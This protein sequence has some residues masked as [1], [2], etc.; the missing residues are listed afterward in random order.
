MSLELLS[1]PEN[2]V[3]LGLNENF[4]ISESL[5]K[6]VIR[7][8][9]SR[10]D[11]R[12]YPEAFYDQLA[13]K[14]AARLGLEPEN[15]VV[16]PGSDRLIAALVNLRIRPG[17]KAVSIH[18]TFEEFDRVVKLHGGCLKPVLLKPDNFQLDLDRVMAECRDAALVYLSSP[19][20]PTG[21][22]FPQEEVEAIIE[23]LEAVVIVDEAYAEYADYTL[24]Q[25][26]ASRNNLVV[27]RTFSKAWG[28]AGL[29]VGYAVAS[30]DLAR[31]IKEVLGPFT[32]SI[33]SAKA[34]EIMLDHEVEVKRAVRETI[35][36]REEMYGQFKKMGLKPYRSKTNF[37][38]VKT[39]LDEKVVFRKLLTKGFHV[40]ELSDK[41]L[42]R[43]C[44]RVTMAPKTIMKRFI[45]ALKEVIEESSSMR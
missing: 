37:I 3:R 18:P 21:N 6:N 24:A 1:P 43:N 27:L 22:Q 44:I 17:A 29:R 26:A 28:L 2:V 15:I 42:C 9:V 36:V 5:V 30:S 20:N 19:N 4:F 31:S 34:A 45:N 25:E 7:E 33:V 14:I 23:D 35:K 41:P 8:A 40:R 39:S 10:V 12:T 13:C 11:P 38:M 32:V 16:G